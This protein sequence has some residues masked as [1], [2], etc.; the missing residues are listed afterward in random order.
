MSNTQALKPLWLVLGMSLAIT[1]PYA[2]NFYTI[3]GP[4]G[5]P[6]IVQKPIEKPKEISQK[7]LP[8]KEQPQTETPKH[9]ELNSI[10]T[11]HLT[12]E[13]TQKIESTNQQIKSAPILKNNPNQD[14]KVY[15]EA[16]TSKLNESEPVSAQ[17]S[18][19]QAVQ[20]QK[21]QQQKQIVVEQKI[22][23]NESN[24]K[25]KADTRVVVKTQ[26]KSVIESSSAPVI[27]PSKTTEQ[28]VTIDESSVQN[29]EP[30]QAQEP[31]KETENSPFTVIDGQKYVNN[32]YLEDQ[33]FNLEGKKRFYMTPEVGAV[34]GRYETIERQKGLSASLLDR[35]R[36]N[37]KPVEKKAIV[38]APTYY[39]LPQNEVVQNLEKSC[40]T[41]KKI[42]KAKKLSTKNQE[43]GIW[44]VAPIKENFAYEVV[45]LDPQVQNVLLTSYASSSKIPSYYWPLVVF[46]DQ[47]GCVLEGVSGFKN[48]DMQD[49]NLQF[50]AM[51][52]V[53]RKPEKAVYLFLTPLS[54]A[55][56]VENK[57]LTNHGQIKLSVIQ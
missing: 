53:L 23:Q 25:S 44:P 39:R 47:Q 8:K 49:N 54:S 40:F 13:K 30:S 37:S 48:E 24:Q 10:K 52:G 34:H 15:V 7:E 29:L 17:K 45:E 56:D 12:V 4:D 50:S 5:H 38:L 21:V 3:I 26:Q 22:I 51:E 2:A 9:S 20:H 43:V 27:R 31:Q 35:I 14:A 19:Y 16:P 57:Q 36:G 18:Q 41:G 6:M 46:L 42:L 55:I 1:T 11:D 33:E 32:E 28:T